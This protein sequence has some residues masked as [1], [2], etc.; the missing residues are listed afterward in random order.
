DGRVEQKSFHREYQ[1]RDTALTTLRTGFGVE[2]GD[3]DRISAPSAEVLAP[4]V[5]IR[6]TLGAFHMSFMQHADVYV[7]L[8][9]DEGLHVYG[10]PIPDGYQAVDVRISTSEGLRIGEIVQPATHPMRV[11]GSDEEF[12]VI[13][14]RAVIRIP[15]VLGIRPAEDSMGIALQVEV[16]YQ[17]CTERMCFAPGRADLQIMVPL[18]P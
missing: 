6:A 5:R 18:R 1:L 12:N 3:A 7:T 17:A 8:E 11:A 4:G 15:V 10:R 2:P 9:L 14:D 13:E 16:R